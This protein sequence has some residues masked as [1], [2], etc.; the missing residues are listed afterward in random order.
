LTLSL[1]RCDE[2]FDRG[3]LFQLCA[4]ERWELRGPGAKF[5]YDKHH[6]VLGVLAGR[7]A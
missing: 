5:F 3:V 6:G 4:E 1:L 7:V 2:G